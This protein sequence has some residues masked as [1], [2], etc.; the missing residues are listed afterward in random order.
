[1]NI[2]YNWLKKYLI[3]DLSPEDTAKKLTSLGLEVGTVEKIQTIKGGLEGLVTAKVVECEDHPNSDHLHIT[4]VDAGNGE[5]IQVV[6]GAPNCRAGLTT[7]LAT[8]GTTLYSGDE[9]F[10]I[11]KSKIRGSESFGMLCAEDE[12][13]IG[14]SHDGI[15]ELPEGTALGIPAKEY[16][17][18]EDDYL[19]EVD[20]TPNRSDAISHF[21]V[22]RDLAAGLNLPLIRPSVDAFTVENHD[23]IVDVTVENHDACPRYSGVTINNVKVT[24]SPDWLK[25]KLLAIG[26]RPINNVVDVTNFILHELGQPLHAFDGDKIKGNKIVV[27]TLNE[28]TKFTTLDGVERSLGENDLMICNAEEGMCIAGVFGGLDSGVTENTTKVFIESAYF[29]PVSIRKT[30]R[31]HGLN[32]DASFRYERGCD[33]NITIYALKRAAILIQEVA[34]GQISSD[35]I[36][37]YPNVIEDFKVNV[38]YNKIFFLDWKSR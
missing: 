19:I 35:I 20:I 21:G 3:F 25:N 38:T 22:A 13:G 8:V 7:I 14:E 17:K 32:T 10:T 1:M 15:I 37:I 27:K 2:S 11:K 4:K 23:Y 5:L 33:P 9:S 18:I 16:Y 12:I 30:A 28:G 6:C 26:L 24:E 36:D 29:N 31:R 34:G